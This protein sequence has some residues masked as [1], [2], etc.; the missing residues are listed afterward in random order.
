MTEFKSLLKEAG[1]SMVEFA[2][3]N[4]IGKS[5]VHQWKYRKKGAPRWAMHQAIEL[6]EAKRKLKGE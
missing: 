4:R 6:V 2:R 3:R 1:I 5:T